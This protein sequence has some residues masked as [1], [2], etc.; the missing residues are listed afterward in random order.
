MYR[1]YCS[2]NNLVTNKSDLWINQSNEEKLT[3]PQKTQ[4]NESTSS[5]TEFTNFQP[6]SSDSGSQKLCETTSSIDQSQSGLSHSI[7]SQSCMHFLSLN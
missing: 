3:Y 6:H 1:G 5:T 2:E 4:D 7:P